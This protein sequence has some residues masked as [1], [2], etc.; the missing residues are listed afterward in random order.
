MNLALVQAP[1]G[2]VITTAEIRTHLRIDDTLEDDYLVALHDTAVGYVETVLRK[3]LLT[4]RW[5]A[6]LD[7]FPRLI[8]LPFSPAQNVNV[9]R[10]YDASGVLTVLPTTDYRLN[11]LSVPSTIEPSYGLT[12]PYVEIGRRGAVEVEFTVGYGTAAQVPPTVKHALRL[13]VAHWYLNREGVEVG[14]G[15]VSL[16]PPKGIDALL[17]TERDFSFSS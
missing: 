2:Q 7:V 14:A 5:K 10:Y 8:E 9:I 15:I 13:L 4:Q 3:K 12:F 17:W 6:F 11:L 1:S 16:E